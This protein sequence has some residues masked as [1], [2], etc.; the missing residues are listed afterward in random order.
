MQSGTQGNSSGILKTG[1]GPLKTHTAASNPMMLN[2]RKHA[3]FK[4]G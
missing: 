4:A 3:S 2:N 1:F